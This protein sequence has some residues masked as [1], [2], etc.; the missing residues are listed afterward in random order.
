MWLLAGFAK[1][2]GAFL[3]AAARTA[4]KEKEISS[5]AHLSSEA[6]AGTFFALGRPSGKSVERRGGA[7]C[8]P[9]FFAARDRGLSLAKDNVDVG[10]DT[11]TAGLELPH[12]IN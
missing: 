7:S 1:N 3:S 11:H 12:A 4:A 10:G 8:L 6:R 5:L 9:L 2:H